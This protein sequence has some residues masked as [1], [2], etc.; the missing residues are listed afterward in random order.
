VVATDRTSQVTVTVPNGSTLLKPDADPQA[1]WAVSTA[2]NTT[3][4]VFTPSSPTGVTKRIRFENDG[5]F[6]QIVVLLPTPIPTQNEVPRANPPA[7]TVFDASNEK[8]VQLRLLDAAG[9]PQTSLTQN[10]VSFSVSGTNQITLDTKGLA[11]ATNSVSVS[12]VLTYRGKSTPAATL[13][14]NFVTAQATAM[15]IVVL[16]KDRTNAL[17]INVPAGS[18]LVPV[19]DPEATWTLSNNSVTF[20]PN[21]PTSVTKR[22]NYTLNGTTGTIIVLLPAIPIPTQN[23]VPRLNPPAVSIFDAMK[24]T[25]VQV[26]LIDAMGKAQTS[27]IQNGVVFTVLGSNQVALNTMGLSDGTDSVSFSYALRFGNEITPAV[28]GTLSFVPTDITI[29]A[30]D[31]TSAVTIPV[32]VGSRL[33]A[34]PTDP[35][36]DWRVST[37]NGVTSIIFTPKTPT[38]VTKRAVYVVNGQMARIVVLLPATPIPGKTAVPRINPPAVTIFDAAKEMGVQLTLID[39]MGREQT[40]ITVNGVTWSVLGTIIAISTAGLQ[41]STTSASVSYALKF[42]GKVTP[43][44]TLTLNF[45]SVATPVDIS[46]VTADRSKPVRCPL[47]GVPILGTATSNL[48]PAGTWTTDGTA[49]AIYTFPTTPPIDEI[50]ATVMYKLSA[51]GAEKQLTLMILPAPRNRSQGGRSRS[52][53]VGYPAFDVANTDGVV[54]LLNGTNRVASLPAAAPN[55]DATWSVD[56]IMKP[57]EIRLTPGAKLTGNAVSVDWVLV[58]NDPLIGETVSAKATMTIDLSALPLVAFSIPSPANVSRFKTVSIPV[59]DHCVVANGYHSINAKNRTFGATDSPSTG[60]W[61]LTADANGNPVVTVDGSQA[62]G[63]GVTLDYSIVDKTGT[64]SNT[65][66]I[67]VDF[68][69]MDKYRPRAA[70]CAVSTL[71]GPGVTIAVDVLKAGISYFEKDPTSVKLLGTVDTGMDNAVAYAAVATNGKSLGSPGQGTWIVDINGLIVYQ[72]DAKANAPV[73]PAPIWYQFADKQ[74]N[75]STPGKVVIDPDTAQ[76]SQLPAKMAGLDETAF[77]SAY[78]D[79]VSTA[80]PM[81]S[82]DEF[83]VTTAALAQVTLTCGAGGP[84]PV[85][86][87]DYAAAYK[88]WWNGGEAW[89]DAPGSVTS[90][91][92]VAVCEQLVNKALGPNQSLPYASRYWRLEL[93]ARMAEQAAGY[94][95]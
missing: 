1:N 19:S 68:S 48:P 70:T 32:P 92:L 47:P 62:L 31:R 63:S 79:N 52:T 51:N 78:Q 67:T 93:M 73:A 4:V 7:V 16:A 88:V 58:A 24:E 81:L 33:A 53:A 77:W 84:N 76:L 15:Q 43:A 2:N 40:S 66:T 44:A 87:A 59:L 91:G 18:A 54:W 74:G 23:S 80:M 60:I 64:E 56:Q 45:V 9:N 11:A 35:E 55:G 94:L 3:S 14:L 38:S 10:G 30:P 41:D 86:A 34:L 61:N 90:T 85:S 28:S 12:Y 71:P 75:W 69:A 6:T 17:P 89:D 26:T 39:A 50:T 29:L 42:G 49:T 95:S 8:G 13:N 27:V 5:K 83:I 72:T 20:T 57:R 25:G 37:A 46:I 21:N 82:S 36:A 65:A 22:V